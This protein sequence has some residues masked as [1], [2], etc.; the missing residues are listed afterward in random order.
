MK[1]PNLNPLQKNLGYQFKNI[2]LLKTALTHR[3][4]LN[5]PGITQ[6]YERLEYLGDAIL[7]MLIT[8]YLFHTYKQADEGY[9]T[10]ARSVIVRTKS[11]SSL[12]LKLGLPQYL[13]MSKGEEAGGGKKNFSILEDSLESLI[14]ALYLDGGLEAAKQFFTDQLIPHAQKL[15]KNSQLKDSK[16]L[17]QEKVQSQGLNSP[18]YKIIKE[19]GPDHQKKFTIAV[20]IKNKRIALGNGKNKQEAEQQAAQQ[21]LKLI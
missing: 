16:S 5:E 7:E 8:D 2:D 17:L 4:S 19:S 21:A 11:L 14:G 15:L 12:A 13:Y 18:I 6:S 20:F 10:T 9:L 3:S 1:F